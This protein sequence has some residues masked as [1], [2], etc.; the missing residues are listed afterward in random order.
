MHVLQLKGE[1]GN[2]YF[3]TSS[4]LLQV[5][6][7]PLFLLMRLQLVCR[8]VPPS[9]WSSLSR[10]RVQWIVFLAHKTDVC[11]VSV[12]KMPVPTIKPHQQ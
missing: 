11:Y 10:I 2:G 8:R 4:V 9:A 7:Y 5:A 3:I 1:C 12:R 6:D